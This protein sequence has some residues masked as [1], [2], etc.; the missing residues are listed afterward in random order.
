MR[1]ELRQVFAFLVTTFLGFS[2]VMAQEPLSVT[3]AGPVTLAQLQTMLTELDLHPQ[4][5]AGS[6]DVLNVFISKDGMTFPVYLALGQDKSIIWI[7]ATAVVLDGN[8]AGRLP[9]WQK[10]IELQESIKPVMFGYNSSNRQLMV[11]CP[12]A[13]H[14]MGCEQLGREIASFI[15]AVIRVRVAWDPQNWQPTSG[16]APAAQTVSATAPQEVKAIDTAVGSFGTR[17]T[18]SV[19][20][21]LADIAAFEQNKPISPETLVRDL[22]TTRERIKALLADVDSLPTPADAEARDFVQTFKTFAR[23][24]ATAIDSLMVEYHR[25]M[26]A[27]L[28]APQPGETRADIVAAMAKLAQDAEKDLLPAGNE[29]KASAARFYRH[30]QLAP[31]N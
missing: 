7:R 25:R 24:S 11:R 5:A 10:M 28:N 9:P 23:A 15:S 27:Y 14:N 18:E 4:L 29:F 22:A 26:V 21:Y 20:E 13:N 19:K 3:P 2:A 31:A 6:N 16:T 8:V 30:Y 12:V 1:T 17:L